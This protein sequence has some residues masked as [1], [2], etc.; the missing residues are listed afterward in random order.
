[1]KAIQTIKTS[2]CLEVFPLN[3]ANSFLL[4]DN[5]IV[6][7]RLKSCKEKLVFHD[8]SYVLKHKQDTFFLF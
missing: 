8:L 6:C 1:M 4:Q 2:S 7:L 5:A 3:N